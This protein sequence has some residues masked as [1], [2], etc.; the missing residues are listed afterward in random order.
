MDTPRE[1]ITCH[2]IKEIGQFYL[3]NG[4]P[5][6]EC[7]KCW[8]TRNNKRFRDYH[9]KYYR[10]DRANNPERYSKY[11]R[12][13]KIKYPEKALFRAAKNRAKIKKLDFNIEPCDIIIPEICPVLGIKLEIG[14][15]RG[16]QDSSPTLDRINNNLGY[17]KGNVRVIS[18]RANSLRKDAN[19]EEIKKILID[20]ERSFN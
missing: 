14:S 16:P 5:R 19:L 7:K 13:Y 3:R 18:F 12:A 11:A 8:T 15:G 4:K 2:E 10:E 6:G 9:L 20:M 17:I 1:C